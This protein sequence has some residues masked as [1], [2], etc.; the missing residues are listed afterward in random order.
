MSSAE[1]WPIGVSNSSTGSATSAPC[2]LSFSSTAS[3][4]RSRESLLRTRRSAASTS[5]RGIQQSSDCGRQ[6]AAIRSTSST[7]CWAM[8]SRSRKGGTA[9]SL[10]LALVSHGPKRS[11]RGPDQAALG[12]SRKAARSDD[13]LRSVSGWPLDRPP[14]SALFGSMVSPR[15]EMS[16]EP[17]AACYLSYLHRG[18]QNGKT[19][20]DCSASYAV[21]SATS[22][23]RTVGPRLLRPDLMAAL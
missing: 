1:A 8:S 13:Q 6:R 20:T 5:L 10:C 17:I 11:I 12:P 16:G 4:D 2:N 23:L 14:V 7:S 21:L 9:T 3:E 18:V 15:L 19:S 22:D